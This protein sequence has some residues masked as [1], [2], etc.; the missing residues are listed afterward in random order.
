MTTISTVIGDGAN[1][2]FTIPFNYMNQSEV[3]VFVAGVVTTD[4]TFTSANTINITTP[5]PLGAKV[6]IERLTATTPAVTFQEAGLLKASLL[7]TASTQALYLAEEA[8]DRTLLSINVSGSTGLWDAENNRIS[9]VADPVDN[10][11]VATKGWSNTASASNLAEAKSVRNELYT[12]Q[13]RMNNLSYGSTGYSTY[14]ASTGILDF[15]LSSGPQGVQGSTGPTGATGSQGPVGLE[16]PQGPQGV[17]GPAGSTGPTGVTGATGA[18]G[19]TGL[20]GVTGLQGPIGVT[21][22]QGPTGATGDQ[23]PTGATG[24]IG[25]QGTTGLQGSTG[26]TGP[27]GPIGATGAT[28]SIGPTG[29]EGPQGSTG[30]QGTIGAAGATGSTGPTG[31]EGPQGSTGPQGPTGATGPTGSQGPQGNQGLTGSQGPQGIQGETGVQGSQGPTGN[32]GSTPLGLAFGRMGITAD[33]ILQMEYYGSA[34]DNDFTI[35]SNGYL[36]VSTV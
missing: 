31:D 26:A 3:F 13:T 9:N 10:N 36:S 15:F 1:T 20:Q 19:L 22:D 18:Q 32:M 21:G 30:P 17:Q 27:Q 24:P 25:P 7:N 6:T 29:D 2:V 16:G 4:F 34:S 12:L 11:D 23:G 8:R 35:S 5:P 33:G 28:G 14:D